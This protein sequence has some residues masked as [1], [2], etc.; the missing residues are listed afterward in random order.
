MRKKRRNWLRSS[1]KYATQG[2]YLSWSIVLLTSYQAAFN[3]N[4]LDA[5][6]TRPH[7][8]AMKRSGS[9]DIHASFALAWPLNFHTSRPSKSKCTTAPP[10]VTT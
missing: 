6:L 5:R 10:S 4:G 8:Y 9:S 2:L 7:S 3:R 1:A